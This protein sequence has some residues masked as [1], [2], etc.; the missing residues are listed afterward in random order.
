MDPLIRPTIVAVGSFALLMAISNVSAQ[1]AS[2]KDP[3]AEEGFRMSVLFPRI[4]IDGEFDGKTVHV[5]TDSILMLPKVDPAWGLGFSIGIREKRSSLEINYQQTKHNVTLPGGRPS[6]AKFETYN[7][8]FK[9]FFLTDK[10]LQPFILLG[11]VPYARLAVTD[12]SVD[13]SGGNDKGI[14]T[15]K[16]TGANLG[17]GLEFFFTR[18][19]S[20]CAGV[21]YRRLTFEERSPIKDWGKLKD[22]G[23]GFDILTGVSYVF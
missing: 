4:S 8:D 6:N 13:L 11:W 20:I 15:S 17:L 19:S 14:F 12:V 9:Y 16:V 2:E 21:F 18:K 1:A 10:R 7:I 23:H 5:Y 3:F 22:E